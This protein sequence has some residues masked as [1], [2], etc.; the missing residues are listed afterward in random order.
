MVRLPVPVWP[1]ESVTRTWKVLSPAAVGW[2][3]I[4]PAAE[5]ERPAGS[6]PLMTAQVYGAWPSWA[7]SV[8]RYVEPT[9][10]FG[11]VVVTTDG[12]PLARTSMVALAVA[13]APLASVAENVGV[14]VPPA[15]GVPAMAP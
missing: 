6:A 7:T 9:T 3:S 15:V 4:W 14:N 11:S 13:V 12:G 8:A 1:R 2:P 10:P 5:S